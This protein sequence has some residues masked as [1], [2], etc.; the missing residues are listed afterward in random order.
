MA[1]AAHIA[2]YQPDTRVLA[3]INALC[4]SGQRFGSVCTGALLLALT[5]KLDGKRVTTHWACADTLT[6]NQSHFVRGSALSLDGRTALQDLQRWAIANIREVTSVAIM[7]EHIGFSQRHSTRIFRQESG[8]TPAQWLE[9]ERVSTAKLLI[10]QQKLPAKTLAAECGF[11]GPDVMR[12]VF[13]R[14]TGITP[15]DYQKMMSRD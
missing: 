3:D 9:R 7:A 6:V 5:G 10:A 13:S 2:R 11:S 12:R 1:G 15:N 14:L 4:D 8:L